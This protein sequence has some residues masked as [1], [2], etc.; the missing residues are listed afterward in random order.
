M[1]LSYRELVEQMSRFKDAFWSFQK[2]VRRQQR[3]GILVLFIEHIC[4]AFLQSSPCERQMHFHHLCGIWTDI[5][6]DLF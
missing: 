6:H 1:P 3:L 2:E 4:L 5:A